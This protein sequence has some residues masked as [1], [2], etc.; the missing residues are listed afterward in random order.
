MD[1]ETGVGVDSE[2]R[3]DL[4]AE[5]DSLAGVDSGEGEEN[6]AAQV[7]HTNKFVSFNCLKYEVR[8][9]TS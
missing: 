6:L 1:S 8:L 4:K 3:V 9:E 2:A 5:L 7:L